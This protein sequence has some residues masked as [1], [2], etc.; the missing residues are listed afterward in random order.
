MARARRGTDIKKSLKF[1]IYG[2]QGSRKSSRCLDFARM[3]NE[4]GR[5]FRVLYLDCET[6]SVDFFL[7]DL[8]AEGIDTMNTYIVYT[9]SYDEIEYYVNKAIKN[10]EFYELD[11][12]GEETEDIVLDADGKPFVADAIV[13]DGI[14]VVADN[15]QQAVLNISEKRAGVRAK[16]NG[17]LGD[18]K[19]VA[20]ESAGLEFKDHTKIKTK[21]RSLIRNLITNT[22]KCVA[23]TGRDKIE[24]VMKKDSKNNMQLVATGER[25]PESWDF[26]R[27]EVFTV[28]HTYVDK[29]TGETYALVEN[30]DRTGIHLPNEKLNEGW[31]LLDW[32]DVITNNKGKKAIIT[33]DSFEKTI[34]KDEAMYTKDSGTS[35][36]AI[37]KNMPKTPEQYHALI[38]ESISKLTPVQKR[39]LTVEVKKAELPM[40]YEELTDIE[41]LQTYLKIVSK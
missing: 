39:A 29:E 34:E 38:K 9:S 33:H 37:E 35:D 31:T 28:L 41:K 19:I 14:T 27:Y 7:D 5:P 21:G 15:V 18:E 17:L 23:I 3:V 22:D 6:G 4:D 24:K 12:N 1:F 11:D 20:I 16:V 8:E 25:V 36:E 30:K 2:E 26:I 10:E 13:I 40:K 32:Q